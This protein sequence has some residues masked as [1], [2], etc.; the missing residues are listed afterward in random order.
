[1]KDSENGKTVV[2]GGLYTR[3]SNFE[4]E[5]CVY[6]WREEVVLGML[7]TEILEGFAVLGLLQ[8]LE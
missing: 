6:L 7:D 8:G 4:M 5:G 2:P 3:Q 1:M